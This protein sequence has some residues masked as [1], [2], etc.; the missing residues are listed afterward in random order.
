MSVEWKCV[1]ECACAPAW[2]VVRGSL[3]LPTALFSPRVPHG[4][5]NNSL[6]D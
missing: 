4:C 5:G 2:L 6:K 1:S 3:A